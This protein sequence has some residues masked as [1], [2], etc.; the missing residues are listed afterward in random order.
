MTVI[1]ALL[2]PLSCLAS[3]SIHALYLA[4]DDRLAISC[5]CISNPTNR[6]DFLRKING[7][8]P[9]ILL[10]NK[11]YMDLPEVPLTCSSTSGWF[12]IGKLIIFIAS[13]L[14]IIIPIIIWGRTFKPNILSCL[15]VIGAFIATLSSNQYYILLTCEL[16]TL[17]IA[18][19][20]IFIFVYKPKVD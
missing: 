1:V 13:V 7:T 18:W 9:E 3:I 12:I 11:C 10:A 20:F 2:F 16:G 5:I 14:D 19:I 8:C 15:A 17:L 6:L 4:K